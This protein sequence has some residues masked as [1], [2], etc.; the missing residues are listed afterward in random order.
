[1]IECCVTVF[2]LLKKVHD[3]SFIFAWREEATAGS[4]KAT[5]SMDVPPLFHCKR[6]VY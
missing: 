2:K 6:L 4:K 5:T 3:T 1:M